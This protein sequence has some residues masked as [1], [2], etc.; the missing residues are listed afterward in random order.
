MLEPLG[1]PADAEALYVVLAAL[2]DAT[3]RGARPAHR[4]HPGRGRRPPRH[5]R[6]PR[7]R[8]RPRQRPLEGAAAGRRGQGPEGPPDGRDRDGRASRPTRSTTRSWPRRTAP[9]T[10]CRSSSATRSWAEYARLCEETTDRDLPLR[11]APVRRRAVG[12]VPR[13]AARDLARVAGPRA[14]G[15]P[16]QRLP[17]GLRPRA[18]QGDGAVRAGRGEVADRAGAHEAGALRRQDRL[19]PVD[20]VLHARPRAPGRASCGT[21]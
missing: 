14:R 9:R 1:I 15:V 12:A 10:T 3:A 4:A 13:R 2:D 18:A 19:D 21:R 11:Q 20:A 17:P 7:P 5:A 16:A 6:R 8:G